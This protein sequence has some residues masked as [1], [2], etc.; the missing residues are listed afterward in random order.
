MQRRT[1]VAQNGGGPRAF[2]LIELLVVIAIVAILA[3]LLLPVL[4]RAKQR[5]KRT[6]CMNNLKQFALSDTLYANENGQL[7]ATS[8]Y[9]PSS[10]SVARATIS[11]GRKSH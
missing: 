6:V 8:D 2:T 7:P 1:A 3:A 9:I 11:P 4:A 10:I 5:A